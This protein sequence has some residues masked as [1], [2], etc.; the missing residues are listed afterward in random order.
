MQ[1]TVIKFTDREITSRGGISILKKMIDPSG[2]AAYPDTLPLPEQGSNRAYPPLQQ[3]FLLF[4]S[5]IRCGAE[6]FAHMDIT[7]PD[8]GLQR[9]YGRERLPEHRAFERYFRKFDISVTHAVFG[10]LYRRF[11]NSLKFDNFTPDIDLPVMTRYGE[12]Q[13]TVKGYSKHKPGRRSRHPVMAFVSEIGMAANFWLRSGDAHTANNFKAFLEATLL[14][15]KDGKTGL[16]RLDSG[17]Y[18]KDIFEYLEEENR[19]TDYITAV[20]VYVT[21]QRK[22]AAQKAW[23]GIERGMEI[24][25]FDCQTREW[26]NPCR[27]TAARQ[28]VD[29]RPQAPGKQLSLFEDDIE[30]N[31]YRHTCYVAALKFGAADVWRLY[32][33]RCRLRKPHQGT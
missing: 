8:T 17:F 30:I 27:M 13:G 19:K 29:R 6:R 10:G 1:Q 2:F 31:G 12:Q 32:R 23:P 3:L 5:S 16:L 4:T 18:G 7:R 14:F 25:G 26:S 33:G 22:I 24:T 15:L 28:K 11:F 9:L 21:I 20:P